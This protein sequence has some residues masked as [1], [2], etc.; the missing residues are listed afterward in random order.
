MDLGE[1]GPILIILG[2][3]VLIAYPITV[4]FSGNVLIYISLIPLGL[5][6]IYLGGKITRKF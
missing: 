2:I 5:I 6:L 1:L 4:L 3:F